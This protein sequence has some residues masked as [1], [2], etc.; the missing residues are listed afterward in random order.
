M[1][2]E[3]RLGKATRT[4]LGSLLLVLDLAGCA[5]RVATPPAATAQQECERSGGIWRG[6]RCETSSGGGY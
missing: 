2:D 5:D 3:S 1:L 4:V 6:A